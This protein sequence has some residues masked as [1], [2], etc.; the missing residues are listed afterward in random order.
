M[1]RPAP[2][3]Q[4]TL[5]SKSPGRV[6]VANNHRRKDRLAERKG[7]EPLC[8]ISLTIRFR[9]GAVMTTSVP[10]REGRNHSTNASPCVA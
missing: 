7:F 1:T 5:H 8:Q 6:F 4:K 9:V 10:L 3:Q 2:K